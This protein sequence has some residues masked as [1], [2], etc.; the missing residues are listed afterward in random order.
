MTTDYT[1]PEMTVSFDY[2]NMGRYRFGRDFFLGDYVTITD[3]FLGV[4]S[5]QKLI[6]VKRDYKAGSVVSYSFE[7]GSE[8]TTQADKLKTKFREIDRRTFGITG[9]G[10]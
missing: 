1:N 5:K 8:K 2:D 7:F 3:G 4:K 9:I 10:D 6:K